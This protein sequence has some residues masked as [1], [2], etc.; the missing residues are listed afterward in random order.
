MCSPP[1]RTKGSLS[2]NTGLAMAFK[3]LSLWVAPVTAETHE[4]GRIGQ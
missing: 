2:R 4:T 3:L 1:K